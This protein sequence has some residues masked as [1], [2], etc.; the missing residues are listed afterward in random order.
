MP[1]CVPRLV[2]SASRCP[3]CQGPLLQQ[4]G[5]LQCG[6]CDTFFPVIDG[7]PRLRLEDAAAHPSPPGLDLSILLLTFNEADNLRLLLP[8][9]RGVLDDLE[10]TYEIVV[11]DGGSSDDTEGVATRQGARV[12]VQSRPG[13]GSA[14][15]EGLAACQGDRIAVLDADLSHDPGL[16]RVL[17]RQRDAADL[18]IGSR[19]IHGGGAD[20]EPSRLL[21]SKILNGIFRWAVGTDICDLSSGYR[22]ARRVV[23][24]ALPLKGRDFDVVVEASTTVAVQGYEVREVPMFYKPRGAGASKVRLGRFARSYARLLLRV[25]AER[26]DRL[27]GQGVRALPMVRQA[28]DAARFGLVRRLLEPEDAES[29]LLGDVE[30][31]VARAYPRALLCSHRDE[32]LRRVARHTGMLVQGDLDALPFPD[33]AF[34][35][36]VLCL[37]TGQSLTPPVV[38]EARRV[39]REGGHLV[40][41][42]PDRYPGLLPR[43]P[44]LIQHPT[45]GPVAALL[46]EGFTDAQCWNLAESEKI[47]SV[48]RA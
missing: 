12:H 48:V 23:M 42:A 32:V 11:M 14:Y 16:L 35:H 37:G 19:Y 5:Y 4:D 22:L 43:W 31:Q 9:L 24:Q 27:K 15:R 21:L 7:I 20:T 1:S 30:P 44:L 29:L 25:L 8:P 17:W 40:V 47:W 26:T 3:A 13:Y 36:V 33:A 10:C 39:V 34:A 2:L 45:T 46:Q 41:I 28:M 6:P 18:L 38:A